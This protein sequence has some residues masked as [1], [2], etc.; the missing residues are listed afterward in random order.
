MSEHELWNELGNIYFI[1]GT[2][3]RVVIVVPILNRK[4]FHLNLLTYL[5]ES[6]LFKPRS[7]LYDTY[8]SDVSINPR[9]CGFIFR[10]L[11]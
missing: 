10:A 7:V 3:P 2:Y 9:I 11:M 5:V 8:C 1:F 4:V 6:G